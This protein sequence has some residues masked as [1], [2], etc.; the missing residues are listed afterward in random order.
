MPDV[1]P[2][3]RAEYYQG[4]VLFY[5]NIMIVIAQVLG[6]MTTEMSDADKREAIYPIM[7][8]LHGFCVERPHTES[9]EEQAFQNGLG[10]A[11]T[12]CVELYRE[13]GLRD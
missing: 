13:H 8:F 7:T 5:E 10:H 4:Q 9:D 6:S 11:Y 12:E 2:E 3:E 1:K